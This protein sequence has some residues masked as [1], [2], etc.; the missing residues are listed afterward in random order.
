MQAAAPALEITRLL[1]MVGV[2]TDVLRAL[3]GVFAA[4]CG[5]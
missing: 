4:H 3:A 5:D 1:S 2:G